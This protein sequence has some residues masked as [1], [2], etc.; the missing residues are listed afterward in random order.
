MWVCSS[1]HHAF[2][3]YEIS[4]RK[5]TK[6]FY[7]KIYNDSEPPNAHVPIFLTFFPAEKS[8]P[9]V[10][11]QTTYFG[12]I[13]VKKSLNYLDDNFMILKAETSAIWMSTWVWLPDNR[14]DP[15]KEGEKWHNYI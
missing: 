7:I 12:Q 6:S 3:D 9:F 2:V 14:K 11:N 10:I 15:I 4:F 1:Q 5:N 13:A 8:I